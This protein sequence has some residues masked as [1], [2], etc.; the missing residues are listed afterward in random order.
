MR[1][2]QSKRNIFV[3]K[4]R[5]QCLYVILEIDQARNGQYRALKK[6]MICNSF[7]R[8]NMPIGWQCEKP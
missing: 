6:C 7:Y 1:D 4:C 5:K 3:E 2:M 8:E